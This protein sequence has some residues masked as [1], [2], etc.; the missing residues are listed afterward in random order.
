MFMMHL[1]LHRVRWRIQTICVCVIQ[2]ISIQL[3]EQC[4]RSRSEGSRGCFLWSESWWTD[5]P[6]SCGSTPGWLRQT[7]SKS[8]GNTRRSLGYEQCDLQGALHVSTPSS[9]P[10]L[11]F[12]PRLGGADEVETP[13]RVVAPAPGAEVHDWGNSR[14]AHLIKS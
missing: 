12:S 11:S 7:G 4:P 8:G 10:H 6:R 3:R 1:T 9:G 13:F 14:A 2:S 5:S